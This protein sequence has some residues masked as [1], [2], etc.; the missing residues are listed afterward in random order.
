M[1][2]ETDA[3]QRDDQ[4]QL[5]LDAD[6]TEQS[7]SFEALYTRLEEVSQR[8]EAGGL[9]LEQS[10]ALYEEGVELARRSHELLGGIEQRIETLRQI[11]TGDEG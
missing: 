11:A 1:T 9:S 10:V 8:L 7:D 4:Q 3:T 2:T 6:A 5:P